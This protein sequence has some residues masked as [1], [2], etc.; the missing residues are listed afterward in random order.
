MFAQAQ[1]K[2]GSAAGSEVG[3]DS[4]PDETAF[5]YPGWIWGPESDW[6]KSMLLFFDSVALLVPDYMRDRP[7]QAD[8]AIVSGLER[9]GLLQILSPEELVDEEATEMLV[10]AMVEAI[11][12]GMFDGLERADPFYALSNSRIGLGGHGDLGLSQMLVDELTERGL[13]RPSEDGVSIP[14]HRTVRSSVLVLL[15]Q[16]LRVTAARRG[17]SLAP[18]TD[19][20]GTA[21][22]LTSLLRADV[23]ASAGAGRVVE[24]D[25]SFVAPDLSAVSLEE[26]L[27]FRGQHGEAYRAYAR[28]LRA[29]TRELQAASMDEQEQ[30]LRDRREELADRAHALN[31]TSRLLVP[32]AGCVAL[33][34]T[35]GVAGFIEGSVASGILGA[36]SAALSA[37]GL[38]QPDPVDA[39]SYMFSVRRE[40][41]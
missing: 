15:A 30:I 21:K 16:I 14:L 37:A 34:V 5:Y 13:A 23:A 29:I 10:G 41:A 8:P 11:T 28:G 22:G 2:G 36:L 25:A 38:S 6:P 33:G 18:V 26:L 12:L 27:D 40:W 32:A 17:M 7:M 9:E 1:Y 3:V 39:L 4:V 20:D 19:R 24:V 35:A 31:A